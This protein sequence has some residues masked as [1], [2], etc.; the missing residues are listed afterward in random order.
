VLES[1]FTSAAD[2]GAAVYWY[3]PVRLLMKDQFRSDLII[4]KVTTPI[5]MLHG[6]RDAIVP[7]ALGERLYSLAQARKRFVRF[8]GAGHND[9]A[10]HGA[11]AE[12]MRFIEE[13]TARAESSERGPTRAPGSAGR[14][15]CGARLHGQQALSLHAFA[16]KLAGA[17]Y[18]LCFLAR[19]SFRW[20]FVMAA[21]LHL[22]ENALALHLLFQR[23]ECLIDIVVAN[24][25]LHAGFL[26]CS[27]MHGAQPA[28]CTSAQPAF[29][30]ACSRGRLK[31]PTA[32][33][34]IA[35]EQR[36]MP[37]LAAWARSAPAIEMKACARMA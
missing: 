13:G 11:L 35:A 9:L 23:F 36:D 19:F 37:H 24:E 14:T 32:A 33:A 18:R 25:N 10:E 15:G 6:D 28:I 1:A 16:R 20:L 3:L 7:I 21:K 27:R 22:A 34:S 8:P 12:A 4:G 2:V 17:A 5:L 29:G 30:R 26:C 31:S